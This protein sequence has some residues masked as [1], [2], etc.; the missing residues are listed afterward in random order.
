MEVFKDGC[1]HGSEID[2]KVHEKGIFGNS[3][4]PEKRIIRYDKIVQHVKALKTLN[5]SIVLTSGTFD[6][7]HIGHAR[8]LEKAKSFGDILI[9]GIDSDEKVRRRKGP[10]RPIIN[11]DER[12]LMIASL[13]STDIVTIKSANEPNWELIRA[14]TPDTLIVTEETYNKEQLEQLSKICGKVIC[15]A[16]QAT[17]STSAK[18]R[19]LQVNWTNKIINPIEEICLNN[20][21]SEQLIKKLKKFLVEN[22]N[23]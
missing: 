1:S 11:E 20:G 17:T 16:P 19:Q 12:A 5:L 9:V 13:R 3:S 23:G 22:K 2:N 14:V 6:L 7:T 8:Y 21:A 10:E 18:I 4:N 15:L